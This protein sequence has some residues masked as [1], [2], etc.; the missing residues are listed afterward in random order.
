[1]KCNDT[2]II[3]V[4]IIVLQLTYTPGSNYHVLALTETV[5]NCN[6]TYYV[7]NDRA[8]MGSAHLSSI[9]LYAPGSNVLNV[10]YASLC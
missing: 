3:L 6:V 8:L 9:L 4:L 5:T 1:M 2:S 10:L 7:A